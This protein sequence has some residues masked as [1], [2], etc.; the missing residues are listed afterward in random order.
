MNNPTSYEAD[1]IIIGAG[2]AGL[3]AA[4][5]LEQR[6]KTVILLEA[7][8]RPGGRVKTDQINGFLLD[9]GFQVLLTAYPETQNLLDYE[10]LRLKA[11][12]PGALIMNDDGMFEVTDPSRVPSGIFK[13]LF[14][15]IGTVSDKFKMLSLR[16]TLKGKSL[17][18]IFGQPEISTLDVLQEYG[19]SEHMLR[20]FFQPFL[21]GIFLENALTTS[22]REFDFVFK[23]FSTA[24]TSVPE[25]G[26]EEIPKQL[27]AKL[28]EGSILCNHKVQHIAEH[29]VTTTEGQEFTATDILIATEPNSLLEP[30]LAAE[31]QKMEGHA[32]TC[33]YLTTDKAPI[34]KPL[35]GLNAKAEKLVNNISVMN[36]VSAA[37]APAGQHLVAASINGCINESDESLTQKI[38]DELG[39]WFGEDMASWKHLKT[40]K[41][42]YALPDQDSVKHDISLEKIKLK[43]GLYIAGDYL[44]NGS[45]NGA[46]RSGRLAAEMIAEE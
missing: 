10:A 13:T 30:F 34:D 5:T 43:E 46:M 3:T 15:K 40:Y 38:K 41:I 33:V 24:D 20:S 37:Y 32:T 8:D 7:T 19:F 39:Q 9:R 22:R 26:M 2:L 14:A 42:P 23:M 11:F 17:E 1:V 29:K 4:V 6:G 25:L 21:S 18:E 45:I 35:I 28:S 12:L 44:L 31:Q 16:N 27:A 36:Q